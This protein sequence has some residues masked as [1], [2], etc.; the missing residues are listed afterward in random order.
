VDAEVPRRSTN[1]CR[2]A[3]KE[4]DFNVT[5]GDPLLDP[6]LLERARYVRQYPQFSTLGFVTTLQWLHRFD[7]DEFFDAGFTWLSISTTLSGREK[8]QEFFQVDKYDHMLANL[9]RLIEENDRREQPL[10]LYIGLKPT[11][12]PIDDVPRVEAGRDLSRGWSQRRHRRQEVRRGGS[13]LV[14]V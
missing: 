5:I 14:L 13:L 11:D 6:H 7:L 9:K 3:A 12:E 1:L 4:L 2:W 10:S 8:Y